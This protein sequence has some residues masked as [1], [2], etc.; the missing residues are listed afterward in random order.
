MNLFDKNVFIY[1]YGKL[2]MF[3]CLLILCGLFGGDLHAQ[4]IMWNDFFFLAAK[5]VKKNFTR[6][7]KSRIQSKLKVKDG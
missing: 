7:A 3:L 6:K 2:F 1:H 5:G 4:Y